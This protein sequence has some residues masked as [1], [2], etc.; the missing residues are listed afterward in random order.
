MKQLLGIIFIMGVILCPVYFIYCFFFSGSS[1][2]NYIIF[3][4]DVV[5][6]TLGGVRSVT[7]SNAT[8]NNPLSLNLDPSMNPVAIKAKVA[9]VKP[10]NSI[11]KSTHYTMHVSKDAEILWEKSFSISAVKKKKDKKTIKLDSLLFP[12]QKMLIKRFAITEQGEYA[13]DLKQTGENKL[14]IAEIEL[15]IKKNVLVPNKLILISGFLMIMISVI[16]GF[17]INKKNLA[18]PELSK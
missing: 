7:S 13:I 17:V 12:N 10:F 6:I 18:E 11:R 8:W 9:Y 1:I 4:Q 15:I 2:G 16:T 5:P 3:K 14:T